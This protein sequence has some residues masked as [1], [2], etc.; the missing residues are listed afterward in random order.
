M[1]EKVP[2]FQSGFN[3]YPNASAENGQT[4]MAMEEQR[5]QDI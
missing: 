5:I 4:K 1:L 3:L 2:S